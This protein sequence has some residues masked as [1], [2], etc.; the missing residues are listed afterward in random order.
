MPV[1]Y[2][3]LRYS[4]PQQAKG[5]S[6]RRQQEATADWCRRHKVTLDT[7]LSLRDEGVSAFRGKHRENPDVHGLACFLQAVKSGRVPEGSYLVVENLD[8]LSREAIV[9]AVNLF[10]GILLAGVRVV[11]LMPVEVVYTATADMS[12]IMLAIVELSRGH[13]ESAAKSN[14]VGAAWRRKQKDA[15]ENGKVMTRRIPGWVAVGKAGK[16]ALVPAK[17]AVVRDIFARAVAG[18][19][20]CAIARALNTAGVPPTG[21]RVFKG[22]PVVWGETMVRHVLTSRTVLGEYQPRRGGQPAGPVVNDYYPRVV[23]DDAYYRAQA[24]IGKHGACR[25][26]RRGHHVN[27]FAGLLRVAGTGDHLIY[28]HVTGKKGSTLVTAGTRHGKGGPW[29]SYPAKVFER[30]VLSRLQEVTAADIEP[31]GDGPAAR[32]EAASARLAETVAVIARWRAKME[33][34]DLIDV[35]S[36]KLAELEP[37]RRALAAE[38]AAAQQ[39]AASPLAETWGSFRSL[40]ALLGD[41]GGSDETREKV[42]AALRRAVGEVVCLFASAGRTRLAA[43]QVYF[44]GGTAHRDYLV[45]YSPGRSNQSVKRPGRTECRSFADESAGLDLRDPKQAAKLA[46]VLARLD[47]AAL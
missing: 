20:L 45:I 39:E 41:D 40:A 6:A 16:L 32:V 2:S 46:A 11:Q 13:S 34:P 38:L 8:R 1:C 23:D 36:E 31:A 14:R 9:P 27:L 18:E 4:S 47:V 22:R 43:V 44:R 21:R 35:V 25:R 17:A 15:A 12:S 42:R 7:S 5:D 33:N 29:C 10:T 26:G 30:A 37:K 24:A 28:N 3:Y 19:S